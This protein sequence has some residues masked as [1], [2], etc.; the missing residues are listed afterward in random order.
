MDAPTPQDDDETAPLRET[1]SLSGGSRIRQPS[2]GDA[3]TAE[4]IDSLFDDPNNL[5]TEP[6]LRPSKQVRY[7]VENEVSGGFYSLRTGNRHSA[8][9]FHRRSSLHLPLHR[10]DRGNNANTLT[11][12]DKRHASVWKLLSDDAPRILVTVF[13]GIV[14]GFCWM[15]AL[16]L[17]STRATVASSANNLILCSYA[18]GTD[19]SRQLF[20]VAFKYPFNL[21]RAW[22][23]SRPIR[24]DRR[25]PYILFDVVLKHCH[26]YR[27]G[28]ASL[29][30][31]DH[32][33]RQDFDV[34]RRWCWTIR[35]QATRTIPFA[36]NDLLHPHVCQR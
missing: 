34:T 6:L 2:S 35:V 4:Q 3:M 20:F 30:G 17:L 29:Q 22:M 18:A 23:Y 33:Y 15:N 25:A 36:V 8:G 11:S 16:Q 31:T 13:L 7:V 32:L 19:R 1:A 12:P 27:P 14:A 21:M 9:L 5:F 24:C 26:L 28:Q 10:H